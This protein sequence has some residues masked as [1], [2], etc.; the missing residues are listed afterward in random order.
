MYGFESACRSELPPFRRL[1]TFLAA[2]LEVSD[3]IEK[4]RSEHKVK[5]SSRSKFFRFFNTHTSR[6]KRLQSRFVN[7]WIDEPSIL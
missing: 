4:F 3:A 1:F 2:N 5:L 6:C 7:Q